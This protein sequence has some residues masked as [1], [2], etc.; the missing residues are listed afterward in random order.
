YSL[1]NLSPTHPLRRVS[2]AAVRDQARNIPTNIPDGP[3]YPH[4]FGNGGRLPLE[5]NRP[6]LIE[7]PAMPDGHG[8]WHHHQGR[9][10]GPAKIIVNRYDHSSPEVIYHDPT[11]P[12]EEGSR[13][14]PFSKAN[15]R[16]R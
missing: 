12:V 13:Y 14:R 4:D 16:G 1:P 10:P 7:Y 15:Y 8:S 9:L 5:N 6:P 2:A 11:R 3:G